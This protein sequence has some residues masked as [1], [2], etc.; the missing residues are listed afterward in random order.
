MTAC[1]ADAMARGEIPQGDAEL[2][3]AMALGVV[4]QAAE[5]SL[6]GRIAR[7]LTHYVDDFTRAIMAVLHTA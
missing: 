7:P 6:Y 1:V 3:S 2:K 5:Y 4:M